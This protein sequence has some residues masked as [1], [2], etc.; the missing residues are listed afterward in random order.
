MVDHLTKWFTSE[1]LILL[2][3][4]GFLSLSVK[5]RLSTAAKWYVCN[6]QKTRSA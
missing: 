4:A 2:S 5:T 3:H 6:I 1:R